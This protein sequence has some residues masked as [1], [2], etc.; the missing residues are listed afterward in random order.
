MQREQTVTPKNNI[1]I[2]MS[3]VVPL[4][5]RMARVFAKKLKKKNV[6]RRLLL[7]SAI[8]HFEGCAPC[9]SD[10]V[11]AVRREKG[12]KRVDVRER[13]GRKYRASERL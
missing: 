4:V 10:T 12:R 9:R 6:Q 5:Y 8:I 11:K 7:T 1:Y 3:L 13:G 2:R